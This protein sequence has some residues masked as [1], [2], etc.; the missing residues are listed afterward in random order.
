VT[1][2]CKHTEFQEICITTAVSVKKESLNC[3]KTQLGKGA[4]N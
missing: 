4:A 2:G 3:F 1:V